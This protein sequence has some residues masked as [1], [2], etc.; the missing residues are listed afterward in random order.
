M[1]SANVSILPAA[2][3]AVS[4]VGLERS[5]MQYC[6]QPQEAPFDMK[7]VPIET[8]PLGT[9]KCEMRVQ[10]FCC[11]LSVFSPLL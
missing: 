11:F 9:T 6:S 8:M 2:G 1:S 4:V 3:L 10:Q 5:L 7:T